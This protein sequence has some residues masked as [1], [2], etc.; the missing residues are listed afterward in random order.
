[1]S[2]PLIDLRRPIGE[3]GTAVDTA[4]REVG[5]FSV[6]GHGVPEELI[7]EAHRLALAFFDL[8][9]V[10]RAEA[11][12][13]DVSYPYG[14]RPFSA[15]ALNR[16]IGGVAPADL[17]ETMNIGPVHA[18][19]RPLADMTDPDERAVYAPNL[20]PSALLA[21]RPAIEAYYDAMS[22]LSS[23]LMSVFAVALDLDPGWFDP[24]VDRH[25]SALRL[26]HYPALAE[27]APPGSFRAGAHTDYGTL[28]ILRLDDEPGLQVESPTGEWV[29]VDAPDGALVINLG[30]LMQRWT[31]DRW[32]STMHRVVV[33]PDGGARRRLT[34]PFFHNAN[35][36]A[37]VECIVEPGGRALHDPVLAGAHLLAKFRST[38]TESP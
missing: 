24:F 9:L 2:V 25:G 12:P 8:P 11:E 31:N 4:C 15:E 38:V 19:P 37:R 32:R 16:S 10:D 1:M 18:P 33:P 13:D 3:V 36:D 23:R 20:W 7:A 17:K 29:D 26:A 34:M 22:S 27:P 5:F 21:F 6:V 28:T 14:Y 30:D 35:W